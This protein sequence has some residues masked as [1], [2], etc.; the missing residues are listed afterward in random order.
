VAIPIFAHISAASN[1]IPAAVGLRTFRKLP[2]GMRYLAFLSILACVQL[3]AEFI[4]ASLYGNNYFLA[5]YYTVVEFVLLTAVFFFSTKSNTAR[6]I[7]GILL[8]AFLVYW[9]IDMLQKPDS[10][11]I[12]TRMA[13]VSRVFLITM[14]L[15]GFQG[16]LAGGTSA[17][18]RLPVFWVSFAVAVYS[19]GTLVVF[20]LSNEL[21]RM[22]MI[23]F[24]I[25][26]YVNWVLLIAVNLMYS[27]GMLCTETTPIS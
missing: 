4:V 10:L 16:V 9:I 17:I 11:S 21:L 27:K 5:D 20:G 23:Y 14:A 19:A 1:L 2:A 22:G 13:M 8:M 24:E 6:F 7:L 3:V 15:V 26:W 25:A 12:N 18:S